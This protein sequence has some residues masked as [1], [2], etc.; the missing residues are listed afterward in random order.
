MS[1]FKKLWDW[2]PNPKPVA[3]SHVRLTLLVL[4]FMLVGFILVANVVPCSNPP[5]LL[6]EIPTGFVVQH[7]KCLVGWNSTGSVPEVNSTVPV[8]SLVPECL[9]TQTDGVD[10]CL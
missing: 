8:S 3:T 6:I 10:I 5:G 7:S 1:N 4:A 9:I 2:C